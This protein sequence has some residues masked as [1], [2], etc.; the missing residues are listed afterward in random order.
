MGKGAEAEIMTDS[1]YHFIKWATLEKSVPHEMLQKLMQYKC[2]CET[3]NQP[4]MCS[5][6]L[7]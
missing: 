4:Y 5:P 6:M 2:L 3:V 7:R 1:R